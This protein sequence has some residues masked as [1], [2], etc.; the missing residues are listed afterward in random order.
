MVSDLIVEMY[1]VSKA[2]VNNIWALRNVNVKI[3]KGEF[4]FVVGPSGAGKSTFTRLIYREETP[5]AGQLV[6]NGYNVM[7]M[8]KCDIPYLRRKVGVVF[9]DFK[10]LADRTVF[11]NVAFAMRVTDSGRGQIR[12]RVPAVLDLVGLRDKKDRLPSELSGGEQQRVALARAIVNNPDILIADE[13]TGNL[14][15]ATAWGIMKILEEIN[16]WGTTIIMATHAQN[17]VDSMGKRVLELGEGMIVRDE[18]KGAYQ[19]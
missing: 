18:Y 15:P 7:S 2:Y 8:R 19:S 6:V 1:D 11:D 10:L 3:K 4:V 13:P 14:D 17:I 5:T 12:R 9:Q 16:V